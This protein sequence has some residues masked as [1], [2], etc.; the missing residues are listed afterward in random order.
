MSNLEVAGTTDIYP[1][2]DTY[3]MTDNEAL[4]IRPYYPGGPVVKNS[5]ISIAYLYGDFYYKYKGNLPQDFVSGKTTHL[6]PGIYTDGKT[7][8]TIMVEPQT[9]EEK[10]L[11]TYKDKIKNLSTKNLL[12]QIEKSEHIELEIPDSSKVFIP[13]PSKDDDILK[14]LI[15][16]ALINKNIDIDQYRSRFVDKNALF[17]FKQVLKGDNALSM[18][19]FNRGCEAL[20]LKYTVTVEEK[21]PNVTIG[22]RLD[23]MI[24][25]SSEDTYDIK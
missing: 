9:E 12:Q 17:N 18:L 15:K 22:R 25:A 7:D 6:E 4:S 23:K 8:T 14:R 1:S 3:I 16:Q 10:K 19:L 2:K 11:Y 5:L 24:I 21:D 20:N 13:I